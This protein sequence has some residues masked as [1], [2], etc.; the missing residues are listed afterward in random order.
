M[1]LALGIDQHRVGDF[2]LAWLSLT[3]RSPKP[4][5]TPASAT[6]VV[7]GAGRARRNKCTCF[8]VLYTNCV[9]LCFTD[10]IEF[11]SRSQNWL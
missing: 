5:R 6:V 3:S 8:V 11:D 4:L 10:F 9:A 7:G 1:G 2:Y